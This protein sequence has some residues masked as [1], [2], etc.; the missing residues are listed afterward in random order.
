MLPDQWPGSRTFVRHTTHMM[1][2]LFLSEMSI[3]RCL[4]YC[5]SSSS[6]Q[7]VTVIKLKKHILR[8]WRHCS[9]LSLSVYSWRVKSFALKPTTFCSRQIPVGSFEETSQTWCNPTRKGRQIRCRFFFEWRC[10]HSVLFLLRRHAALPDQWPESRTATAC[11]NALGIAHPAAHK[12]LP[13]T[14]KP[15]PLFLPASSFLPSF[16]PPT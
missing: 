3:W 10:H 8:Y 14:D 13:S 2:P 5:H 4:C 6:I 1:R 11:T 7:S 15:P 12:T 9:R 16:L